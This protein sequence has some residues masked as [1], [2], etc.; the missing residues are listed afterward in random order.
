[1]Q[2]AK[3]IETGAP[4]FAGDKTA[5]LSTELQQLRDDLKALKEDF[6]SLTATATDEAKSVFKEKLATAEEKVTDAFETGTGELKEIQRQTEIAIRKNPLTALAAA[7]AI[8]FFVAG[9][10]RR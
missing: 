6:K 2:T 10:T 5:D 1:M 9:V 7:A 8:G 3:T 4:D